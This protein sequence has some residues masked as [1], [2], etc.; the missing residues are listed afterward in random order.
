MDALDLSD[1]KVS[2]WTV[3]RFRYCLVDIFDMKVWGR[4][5]NP[6]DIFGVKVWGWPLNPLETSVVGIFDMKLWDGPLNR[7][8]F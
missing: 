6:S 5:L 4:P 7:L 1:M 8:D 3:K 2:G